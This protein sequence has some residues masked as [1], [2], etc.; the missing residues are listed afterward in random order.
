MHQV[1][2]HPPLAFLPPSLPPS[3]SSPQQAGAVARI[4]GVIVGTYTGQGTHAISED[5]LQR[6][7]R[8][9]ALVSLEEG[10]SFYAYVSL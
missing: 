9:L 5:L 6:V 3:P 1:P 7:T 2:H 10:A 4:D 8:V